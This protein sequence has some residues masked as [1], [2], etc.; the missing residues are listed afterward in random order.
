MRWSIFRQGAGHVVPN[1]AADPGLVF[2]SELP[3][4]LAFLCGTTAAVN[5]ATCTSLAG[6]G[7]S[8]DPS[9]LNAAVDRH[10]QPC[11]LADDHP[12]RHERRQRSRATY[13]PAVT[14]MAGFT[15]P[16]APRR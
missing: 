6:G 3:D 7:Y 14:G 15:S 16:S 1:D 8:L 5:Q 11:R 13:V 9:D 12:P 2:D 4:W 10:R